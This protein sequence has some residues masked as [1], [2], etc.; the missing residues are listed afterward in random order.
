MFSEEEN[1]TKRCGNHVWIKYFGLLLTD[2]LASLH[3]VGSDMNFRQ[4]FPAFNWRM[5]AAEL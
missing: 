2:F 3:L 1:E 4:L 5:I